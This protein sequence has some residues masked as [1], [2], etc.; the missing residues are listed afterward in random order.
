MPRAELNVQ[1]SD[2]LKAVG[3]QWRYAIGLVPGEPNEGLI[4]Q[5]EGSPARLAA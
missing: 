2:V 4:S 3:G 1:D 5:L